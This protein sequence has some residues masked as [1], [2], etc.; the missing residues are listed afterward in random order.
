MVKPR[1]ALTFYGG[2]NEIGGNKI[3]LE[4]G[5][6]KV[7]L[8]FGMSFSLRSQFYSAP[9]L[10]PRSKD[11]LL[12]LGILPNIG[13]IYW[14]D[15]SE[16]AVDA[17]FISHSHMDHV[18]YVSFLKESIPV[19]C[20][21]T[22]KIILD[23]ISQTRPSSLEF[24]LQ[25][26]KLETF[27]TGRKVRIG[28]LEVEPVHVDHSVPGA[29]GFIVYTS[30]G[31]LVYTGDFRMHG[32]RSDMT[33]EFVERAKEAEPVAVV[34]EGTNLTRAHVSSETEVER[35]LTK[36]IRDSPGLVLA[37]FA[38]TD[39]D[40]LRSF[41]KASKENGRHLAVSSKQAYLLKELKRDK[42]LKI[43]SLD[44][45]DVL[46]FQK[47]KRKRYKWEQ[48]IFSAYES[49]VM[50]SAEVNKRQKEL[51]LTLSFY[52]LEELV[53]IQPRAGSCYVLSASEPF[54]EE[55]EI[56]HE[57]LVNWLE[58]Y[59]LPQ[60]QVHV[61]GHIMPLHLRHVLEEINP[62]RIFPVH[63]EHPE[64][65]SKFVSDT[66]GRVV[67]VEKGRKYAI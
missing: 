40:R 53:T 49:K 51:V 19:Y 17:V 45:E 34:S 35:K 12:K 64:L 3:L 27:R 9:F 30:S 23:A 58:H 44:D 20:G 32:A 2:V 4:D 29:Y 61:S 60:Y 5:D 41:Y 47:S 33:R 54:N 22:T 56:D 11:S 55:M 63:T 15:K 14:F 1:T 62:Q 28:S 57:R 65:L 42:R 39:V 10:S 18:A 37:D 25:N 6:V 24:D 59:G 48:E 50:D 16:R 7:F 66:K 13:G 43:P 38:Y 36:I 67:M 31:A 46:I 52:D 26:V 21:E 8:D